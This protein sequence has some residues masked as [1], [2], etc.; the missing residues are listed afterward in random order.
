VQPAPR[1]HDNKTRQ[2]NQVTSTTIDASAFVVAGTTQEPSNPIDHPT[3]SQAG[4]C[5]GRRPLDR[6]RF[7]SVGPLRL[8]FLFSYPKPRKS[9][10]PKNFTSQFVF[11]KLDNMSTPVMTP[12]TSDTIA[13]LNMLVSVSSGDSNFTQLRRPSALQLSSV[14]TS[15]T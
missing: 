14:V 13:V 7:S 6:F 3:A 11:S 8:I 5:V 1:S 15:T 10:T 9:E 2:H 12:V 4:R